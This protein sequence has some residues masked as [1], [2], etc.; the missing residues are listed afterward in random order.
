LPGSPSLAGSVKL[1]GAAGGVRHSRGRPAVSDDGAWVLLVSGNALRLAAVAS[2]NSVALMPIGRSAAAAFAPGNRDAAVASDGAL[3]WIHDAAG[4]A[5][6]QA[7]AQ[8]AALMAP[9]GIAFSADET[10]VYAANAAGMVL[11][12]RLA[13]GTSVAQASGAPATALEPMGDFFRLN[14]AGSGPLWLVDPNAGS[15]RVFFVP[16]ATS[17]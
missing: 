3:T 12:F 17:N 13:D 11:C 7:V 5:T 8:N 10:A 4:G 2:G 1:D 14:Q 16:P 15:P 9:A 6:Q